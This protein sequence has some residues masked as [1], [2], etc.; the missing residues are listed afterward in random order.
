MS[1]FFSLMKSTLNIKK[2]SVS[3]WYWAW[4]LMNDQ[5]SFILLITS[6]CADRANTRRYCTLSRSKQIEDISHTFHIFPAKKE[7][8]LAL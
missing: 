3:Q 8:V 5:V 6:V 2:L 7:A 1:D 4:L